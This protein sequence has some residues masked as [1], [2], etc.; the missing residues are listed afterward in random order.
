MKFSV[1][2]LPP[3]SVGV[4][5]YAPKMWRMASTVDDTPSTRRKKSR[6]R[7]FRPRADLIDQ[8]EPVSSRATVA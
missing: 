2:N 1:N 3:I 4:P 8:L 5:T 7:L 6:L